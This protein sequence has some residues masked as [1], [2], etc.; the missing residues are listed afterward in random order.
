VV[1]EEE[2]IIG[3][4]T[5]LASFGPLM[6]CIDDNRFVYSTMFTDILQQDHAIGA[7]SNIVLQITDVSVFSI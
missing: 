1:D 3:L 2:D 5:T 6:K 4:V 7:I